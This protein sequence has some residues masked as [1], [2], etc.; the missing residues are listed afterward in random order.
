[1]DSRHDTPASPARPH[2]AAS[3]TRA[4]ASRPVRASSGSGT[5]PASGTARSWRPLL[6][7]VS[8]L[9][10]HAFAFQ[11][12]ATLSVTE[13]PGHGGRA[14]AAVPSVGAGSVQFVLLARPATATPP[15]VVAPPVGLT[16]MAVPAAPP[17]VA[18][19]AA[20]TM[21]ASE[22]VSVRAE[23][24][25]ADRVAVEPV[26]VA[27]FEAVAMQP[28]DFGA[29]AAAG[30]GNPD[31]VADA[32]ID[33]LAD[34]EV[35]AVAEAQ[36]PPDTVGSVESVESVE[37]VATLLSAPAPM[38][39]V[40]DE[41]VSVRHVF[42]V[43]LG[44]HS[45]R[46]PVARLEYTVLRDGDHYDIRTVARAEGAAALVY[47]GV[48]TQHSVG[49]VGRDGLEPHR[50]VEQ[51]GN[52]P[53]RAVDF[54]HGQGLLMTADRRS[55]VELPAGT[56]D[57]L[58]VIYQLGLQV[59]AAP[60]KFVAGT[61]HE[62]PVASMSRVMNESFLVVG[63]ATVSSQDGPVRALHLSR[64]A[65]SGSEETTI[66]VWLGYDLGMLPVRVRFSDP[67]GR[68]LDQVI[69]RAG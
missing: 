28:T 67:G 47:S 1:M 18:T 9:A 55:T 23:P 35:D 4:T 60:E 19:S 50:Y 45:H 5:L 13:G 21:D 62:V 43:Y 56:Q 29:E 16:P 24:V 57:R 51:R 31:V 26:V 34:P 11:G 58:S 25:N 38:E 44:T 64:S 59:R 54:D 8:T 48:L 6:L 10:L 14:A 15:P 40:P 32:T 33:T 7:L 41:P 65:R 12:I 52:R 42:K 53:Q 22:S 69:E 36:V 66:D 20:I 68:V 61:T 46:M 27:G 63:E 3:V 30:D 49:R 39:P 2:A 37:A 17:P